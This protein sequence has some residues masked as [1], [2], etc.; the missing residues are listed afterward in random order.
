MCLFSGLSRASLHIFRPNIPSSY[1]DLNSA[2]Q[3]NCLQW[4]ESSTEDLVVAYRNCSPRTP[5]LY[6]RLFQSEVMF[7]F[8]W[9]QANKATGNKATTV[10]FPH[11]WENK[12]QWEEKFDW[13]FE[14]SCRVWHCWYTHVKSTWNSSANNP[15]LKYGVLYFPNSQSASCFYSRG[16]GQRRKHFKWC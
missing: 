12:A 2:F 5:R 14:D 6:Y 11:Y 16:R 13:E 15:N 3:C 1:W 7:T 9:L 10:R 4:S 8:L